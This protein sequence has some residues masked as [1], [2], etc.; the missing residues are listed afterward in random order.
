MSSSLLNA[1]NV[2]WLSTNSNARHNRK[3]PNY[4]KTRGY[5]CSR[6]DGR[7]CGKCGG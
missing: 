6:T 7:P 1:G 4:R 3:C 2:V 5:P